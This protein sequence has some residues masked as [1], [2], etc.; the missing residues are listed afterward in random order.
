MRTV[1][2][3]YNFAEDLHMGP[4]VA[5]LKR[6]VWNK[7]FFLRRSSLLNLAEALHERKRKIHVD[8]I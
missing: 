8:P 2:L 3:C 4:H 1:I 6:C 7:P 5:M